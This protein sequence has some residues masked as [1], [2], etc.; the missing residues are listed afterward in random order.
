MANN[1]PLI[2]GAPL[3][4]QVKRGWIA[5]PNNSPYYFEK[6]PRLLQESDWNKSTLTN[7]YLKAIH[8]QYFM[9]R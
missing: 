3:L 1:K 2:L 5:P 7:R 6:S 9:R 4:S 8:P